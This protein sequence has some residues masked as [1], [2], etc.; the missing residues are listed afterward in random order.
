MAPFRALVHLTALTV[1][2]SDPLVDTSNKCFY[3]LNLV[4]MTVH[5]L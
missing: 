5:G 4:V 1:V 2:Y 3:N